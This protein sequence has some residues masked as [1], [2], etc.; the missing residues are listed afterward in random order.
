ML[1]FQHSYFNFNFS[2][3]FCDRSVFVYLKNDLVCVIIMYLKRRLKQYIFCHSVQ[4]S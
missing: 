1:G 3:L 2:P 4:T